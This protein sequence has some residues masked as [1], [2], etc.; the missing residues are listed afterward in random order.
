MK[1]SLNS[2]VIFERM[3]K[4]SGNIFGNWI[5]S[6]NFR[7]LAFLLLFISFFSSQLNSQVNNSLTAEVK[8][9]LFHV[10]RKSPI[11][12]RNFGYA[13]EYFGPKVP[14]KDG[15]INYDSLETIIIN[16]DNWIFRL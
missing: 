2:L 4:S 3:I 12:E 8:S 9:Y 14:M 6:K 1:H 16:E 15:Q 7:N 5:G 11:L 13:F 10:V